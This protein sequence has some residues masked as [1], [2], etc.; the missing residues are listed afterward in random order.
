MKRALTIVTLTLVAMLGIIPS[1]AAQE[2]ITLTFAVQSLGD[3]HGD[4]E[5]ALA[6]EYMKLHP[7]IKIEAVRGQN[8]DVQMAGGLI[9]D[10]IG[11]QT[12]T[13]SY[14]SMAV[15]GV[16]DDIY[17]LQERY[18]NIP[19]FS[20]AELHPAFIEMH[21]LNGEVHLIP[22]RPFIYGMYTNL[23]LFA[24]GGVAPP[25]D[26]WTWDDYA[27][28][29]E[30][31]SRDT[32]GDG[33]ND[34]WG[35]GTDPIWSRMS[36]WIW[37]NGTDWFTEDLSRTLIDTPAVYEAVDWLAGFRQDGGHPPYQISNTLGKT[38]NLFID[39]RLGVYGPIGNLYVGD[40]RDAEVPFAWDVVALPQNVAK[41]T[42]AGTRG[43][44]IP[45]EARH[46]KE[47]WEFAQYLAG[48][49]AQVYRFEQLGMIG[50]HL[51]LATL[52]EIQRP[53]LP[54][55]NIR[56]FFDAMAYAKPAQNDPAA[57]EALA[58]L[59]RAYQAVWLGE[60]DAK[61]VGEELAPSINATLRE[62]R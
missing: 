39:G 10:L 9:P 49:E 15:N 36:S 59:Q 22:Y 30:K 47:G 40:L 31:L 21:R 55:A 12:G 3:V 1:G 52:P 2:P 50:T 5:V 48:W 62:G 6:E 61:S 43:Y 57:R 17:A 44:V 16:F 8:V 4:L 13:P 56:M 28:V 18:G 41:A 23:D 60:R 26:E 37:Q 25:S 58:Q 14:L 38:A 20:L 33:M 46:H 11:T 54:P 19:N 35:G 53:D 42:Y 7:H 24:R 29:M 34:V 51:R 27:D 45:K 32:S